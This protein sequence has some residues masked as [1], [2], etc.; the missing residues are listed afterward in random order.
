MENYIKSLLDNPSENSLNRIDYEIRR[1][2][3]IIDSYHD[4]INA[5]LRKWWKE[6]HKEEIDKIQKII[7][8]EKE[9]LNHCREVSKNIQDVLKEKK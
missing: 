5:I 9:F 1:T 3:E 7:D 4:T 2:T 6:T 8:R